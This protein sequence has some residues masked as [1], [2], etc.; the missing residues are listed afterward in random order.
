[1]NYANK[2]KQIDQLLN[3]L[4]QMELDTKLLLAQTDKLLNSAPT[5]GGE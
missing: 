1:M 3:Q 2:I 4:K 5:K